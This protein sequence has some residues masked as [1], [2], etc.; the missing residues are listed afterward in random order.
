MV[1]SVNF[2]HKLT[3]SI[4]L[5]SPE[6]MEK[7]QPLCDAYRSA[8]GGRF[9]GIFSIVSFTSNEPS[10]GV[11]HDPVDVFYVECIGRVRWRFPELLLSYEL[12]PGDAVFV[13]AGVKHEVVS[14]TPRAAFSLMCDKK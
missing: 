11:H 7:L 13:P 1:G 3:L 14:L 9:T 2:W 5:F 12:K 8:H 4:D 6:V 10:T